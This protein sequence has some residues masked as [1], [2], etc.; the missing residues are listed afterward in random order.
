MLR[1][2]KVTFIAIA[3]TISSY[4]AYTGIRAGLE[5]SNDF[6]RLDAI[7]RVICVAS[8][9]GAAASSLAFELLVK[10]KKKKE[11]DILI[12]DLTKAM[13][14]VSPDTSAKLFD[15]VELLSH[16]DFAHVPAKTKTKTR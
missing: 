2:I 3:A 16:E 15:V 12:S 6:D 11:I 10:S 9:C 8:G 4:A 7:V 14:H 1:T 5:R 13:E